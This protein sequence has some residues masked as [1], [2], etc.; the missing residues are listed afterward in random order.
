MNAATYELS[1][2]RTLENRGVIREVK[3]EPSQWE[4]VG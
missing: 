2:L 4:V 3:G 1:H